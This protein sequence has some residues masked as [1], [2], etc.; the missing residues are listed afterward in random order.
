MYSKQH[1]IEAIVEDLIENAIVDLF[2]QSLSTKRECKVAL[3]VL[4]EKLENFDETV[5]DSLFD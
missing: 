1:E 5:F 2:S 3:E 4:I